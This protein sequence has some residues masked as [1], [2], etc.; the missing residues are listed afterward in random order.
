MA[1]NPN[2]NT[3]LP[4]KRPKSGAENRR[5]AEQAGPFSEPSFSKAKTATG[6]RVYEPTTAYQGVSS[7][8]DAVYPK[9]GINTRKGGR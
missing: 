4:G 8:Y 6:G 5:F 3:K 1:S 7:R 2:N 9:K